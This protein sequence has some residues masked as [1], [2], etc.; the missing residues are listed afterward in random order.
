MPY[1][2]ES[3]RIHNLQQQS[4]AR[5]TK[6]SS[7]WH[8]SARQQHPEM[9]RPNPLKAQASQG[10]PKAPSALSKPA[11]RLDSPYRYRARRPPAKA[12]SL[13]PRAHGDLSEALWQIR[14]AK[15]TSNR[16]K[17]E[18]ANAQKRKAISC[19]PWSGREDNSSFSATKLY[20]LSFSFNN[21]FVCS[22]C[23]H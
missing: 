1:R 6:C 13:A 18:T 23:K 10:K 14:Y 16:R 11:G 12:A 5:V 22:S 17:S 15:I 20:W 9:Q 7:K 21:C 19:A 4:Q 8:V 3:V 2:G